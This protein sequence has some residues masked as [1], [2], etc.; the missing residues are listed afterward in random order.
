MVEKECKCLLS[1][2]TNDAQIKGTHQLKE[3]ND[4]KTF[5]NKNTELKS[6]I[7]GLNV[8]LDKV[9]GVLY[10]QEQYSRRNYLLIQDTAEENQKNTNEVVIIILKMYY[11]I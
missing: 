3:M 6:P 7:N 8:R 9:D 1:A 4:A 11:N 5:I 2:A 10:N